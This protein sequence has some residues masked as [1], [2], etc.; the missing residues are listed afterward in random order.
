MIKLDSFLGTGYNYTY[1]C[2]DF[3]RFFSKIIHIQVLNSF[4]YRNIYFSTKYQLQVCA[5]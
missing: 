2:N 1:L 3:L 5:N 4:L